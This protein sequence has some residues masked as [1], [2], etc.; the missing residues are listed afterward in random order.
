MCVPLPLIPGVPPP[1][2]PKANPFGSA[3]PVDTASRFSIIERKSAAEKAALQA[4]GARVCV[5]VSSVGMCLYEFVC[6]C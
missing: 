5:C 4:Q 3:R 1:P 2:K 6:V